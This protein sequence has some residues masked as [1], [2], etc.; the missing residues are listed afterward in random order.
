MKKNLR[1]SIQKVVEEISDSE[2]TILALCSILCADEG[3]N[4]RNLIEIIGDDSH[5]FRKEMKNILRSGLLVELPIHR[6]YCPKEIKAF[7]SKNVVTVEVVNSV[8]KRLEEKTLLSIDADLL[9]AKPYFGMAMA[10]MNYIV[11][12]PDDRIDYEV[13]ASLLVNITRYY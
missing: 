2:Q 12:H 7:L 13:F 10:M 3:V 11:L 9:Q 1:N 6:I 8:V 5:A 4:L